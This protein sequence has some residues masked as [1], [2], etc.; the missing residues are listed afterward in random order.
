MAKPQRHAAIRELVASH[1]VTSQEHLRELLAQRGFEAAQATL[2]R[3]IRELR[4]IKVPDAEGRSHYTLPPESWDQS[5]ALTRLRPALFHRAEGTGNL[6]VVRTLPRGAAD[7]ADAHD[8]G[9][10]PG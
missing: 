7:V 10:W 8:R 9:E 1:R 5:P 2:S 4:L 6:L 3:D